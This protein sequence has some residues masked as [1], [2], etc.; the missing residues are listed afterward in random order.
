METPVRAPVPTA[1]EGGRRPLD[2]G[3]AM[4][5][6][7]LVLALLVALAGTVSSVTINNLGASLKSQQ[8]GAALDAADAGV[9]QAF[10]YLRLGVGGLTCSPTCTSN[11]WGNMDAPASA[12]VPGT[13][14]QA[15]AVWIEPIAPSPAN[16]PALYRIHSTGTAKGPARRVVEVDVEV[17]R[18][19]VPLGVYGRT[20]NGGGDVGLHNES[21]FSTGCVYLRSKLQFTGIDVAYGINAAVHTSQ[22]ITDSQ[23][24]G[25]YCAG[26]NKAIHASQACNASYPYDQDHLGGSLLGTPCATTQTGHPNYY[27][28]TDLDGDGTADVN[29]SFLR[30]DA[31]L[32]KL[33]GVRKPPLNQYELADLRAVAQAQGNLWTKATGWT[34]PDEQQ[35]VM[36]FDLTSTDPGGIVDLNDIVGF[37]R[38]AGLSATDPACGKKSLIIII[39]G[40]NARLS[41]NQQVAASVFLVSAAPYGQLLKANGNSLFIGTIYAD[42]LNFTGT[43]DISMDECFVSNLAPGLLQLRQAAYRELDR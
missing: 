18:T 28:A 30:D 15:Y 29:G 24:T 21:L 31:T 40:G 8:A 3:S 33:Y 9:A 35:A 22:I 42:T 36:Y 39:E 4:I 17:G 11:P 34:S 14:G 6:T 26:T 5:V 16:N 1:A 2:E 19:Q 25:Q 7:L 13:A 10:A 27:G 32:Q 37:S 38:T 12:G 41:S 43:A 20:I 23:G